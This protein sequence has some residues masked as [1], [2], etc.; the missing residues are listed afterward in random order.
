LRKEIFADLLAFGLEIFVTR[1][2]EYA[3]SVA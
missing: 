2:I 1:A 3:V